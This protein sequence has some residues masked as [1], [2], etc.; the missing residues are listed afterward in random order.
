MAAGY[1]DQ[2]QPYEYANSGLVKSLVFGDPVSEDIVKILEKI[3]SESMIY[4][5]S[6]N[7]S[8]YILAYSYKYLKRN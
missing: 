2:N 3:I 7:I 4:Q 6:N 1:W 5:I 8:S